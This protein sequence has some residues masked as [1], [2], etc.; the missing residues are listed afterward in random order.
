MLS[1]SFVE[2]LIGLWQNVGWSPLKTEVLLKSTLQTPVLICQV[3][4]S[5]IVVFEEILTLGI[6]A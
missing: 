3:L 2:S 1:F 4:K 5:L 6:V